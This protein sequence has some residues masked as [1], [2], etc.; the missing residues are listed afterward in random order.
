MAVIGKLPP[1]ETANGNGNYYHHTFLVDIGPCFKQDCSKTTEN[2]ILRIERFV[3]R[4]CV[5]TPYLN[6]QTMNNLLNAIY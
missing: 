6:K 5:F 3:N 2:M 4:S 1:V